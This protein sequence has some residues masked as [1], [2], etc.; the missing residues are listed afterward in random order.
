MYYVILVFKK[1][2]KNVILICSLLKTCLFNIS[3]FL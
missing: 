2:E 1:E 3:A